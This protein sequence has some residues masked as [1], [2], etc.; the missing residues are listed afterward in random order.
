MEQEK[1][2]E[3]KELRK[4]Y[5]QFTAVNG[6]SFHINKGEVFGL[7]GPNGAG[8]TTTIKML[9]GLLKADGGSILFQG[10]PMEGNYEQMKAQI[11][12]C[13]QEIMIWDLLTCKEQLVFMGSSYGMTGKE[14]AKRADEVL[15]E[16]GLTDKRDKMAKS[17]SG[18]MQRRLNI[19]LAI[20]HD[21]AI[22]IL[23]EPQAGLDPQSRILVR[24]FIR[25]LAKSKT[26]I[27]TT[28]DMDEA[29]RLSDRIAIID[30]GKVLALDTPAKLKEMSGMG[31]LLQL[32]V[33]GIT[34]DRAEKIM[35][36]LPA[37]VTEKRYADDLFYLGAEDILSLIPASKKVFMQ[38]GYPIE[39][40]MVRKRTLE[41]V[42]IAMT[43]RGLRE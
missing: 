5:R 33:T 26:V 34:E 15:Q 6:I 29:D 32:R 30:H 12:L 10:L 17:L 42:F 24:D 11:G 22:L 1:I 28:H 36:E 8:K 19:A 3:V 35:K 16:L 43:G 39:D 21:P 20:I 25:R 31:D 9:C 41:D 27:L 23:D 2:L 4:T 13:P 18:G 14:A 37:K 38:N 7:L 40:M